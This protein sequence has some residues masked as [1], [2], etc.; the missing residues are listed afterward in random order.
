MKRP[1][2]PILIVTALALA[3]SGSPKPA[4]QAPSPTPTPTPSPAQRVN[5]NVLEDTPTYRIERFKKSDYIRVDAT[6]IRHPVVARPVEFFK[7][8]DEYY[9][10]YTPKVVKG[11][12][13]APAQEAPKASKS[14]PADA[15]APQTPGVDYGMP[16]EDF[17]D[18]VPARVSASFRLEEVSATGL[19]ESGMWRHSF[20]IADMNGDGAPDIVAPPARQ[21]QDPTLHLWLGDGRGRFKRAN[22]GY[23]ENGKPDDFSA[24]YGGV[25]V[26]DI[27]GDGKLDVAMASHSG[28]LVALFGD[29]EGKFAVAAEGLPRREFSSQ[30]VALVDVNG[31]RRLDIVASNDTYAVGSAA[32]DPH[33]IRVYL[34][35][36][37]RGWKYA[38]DA[39]ID[40]AWSNSLTAWDYNGDGRLDVLTGSQA[41]GAVQLLWKN[42]GSG[43]FSTGY[44]PQIEIHGFHFAM[45]PGTF[46]KQRLP[47]FADAFAR[48]TNVPARLQAQGVTVYS[49]RDGAWT[50]HRVWRKKEGKSFLSALAMGDLDGDSL[51]DIVFPDSS[52][53]YRL[54]L[55]LQQADGSF[56][57][58]DEKQEPRFDSP[59]QCVRLADLDGD[60]RLDI[61]LSKT[62]STARPEEPGGWSVYLNRK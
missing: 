7:E 43:A 33:Q 14:Q 15:P 11:E 46:G 47:A 49:F 5:P 55:F 10:V 27:D 40:G 42:E 18:I 36:G 39:L 41:Y 30:A 53:P 38:P 52:D 29:G 8:D 6:H 45:A 31:D 32:W 17:E 1:L 57:E 61:V 23:T 4:S 19:P 34:S 25:A 35:D 50:R 37:A 20:V 56:K 58:A 26:G 13:G 44:F 2:W 60:G 51:D 59:A 24:D 28:G 21:G 16:P 12:P 9:Y 54:R 48:A 62:Y 22:L 3:C